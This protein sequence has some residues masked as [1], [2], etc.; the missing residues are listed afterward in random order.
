[1][2]NKIK[3]KRQTSGSARQAAKGR[4]PMLMWWSE[5]ELEVLRLLAELEGVPMT[6]LVRRLVMV[7][8][9]IRLDLDRW[10]R[11]FDP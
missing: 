11:G 2:T 8:V 6:R 7:A 1:M 3:D 4:R 9:K 5:K 10:P